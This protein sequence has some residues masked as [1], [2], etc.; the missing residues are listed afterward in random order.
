M[1]REIMKH[2]D[3]ADSDPSAYKEWDA[4]YKSRKAGKGKPVETK[5]S[6]YTKK[7]KEL[8]GESEEIDYT[9]EN[10]MVWENFSDALIEEMA[11]EVF[12]DL[13]L[14]MS[15]DE[16]EAE[17]DDLNE[18]GKADTALKNKSKKTGFPL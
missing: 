10:I 3:K 13:S 14:E 5:P 4:D 12:E 15:D 16:F 1:K 7:F 2:K 8:Y 11:F 6:K 9:D 18:G 17:I